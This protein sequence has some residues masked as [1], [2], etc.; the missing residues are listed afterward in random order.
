M[1]CEACGCEVEK[2][3]RAEE[4][5]LEAGKYFFQSYWLALAGHFR[6]R[7][8]ENPELAWD[9]LPYDQKQAFGVAAGEFKSRF[10]CA[11]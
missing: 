4:Y 8:F 7:S 11:G 9:A 5:D 1:M 6:G 10:V 2:P 3:L